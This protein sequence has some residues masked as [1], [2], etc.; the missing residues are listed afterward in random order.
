MYPGQQG[1]P[2]QGPPPP[3]GPYQAPGPYPG[4]QPYPPQQGAPYPPQQGAPYPPY[5]NPGGPGPYPPPQGGGPYPPHGA[6]PHP[7]QHPYPQQQPPQQ[8]API[9][10]VG[11]ARMRLD[12]NLTAQQRTLVIEIQKNVKVYVFGFFFGIMLTSGGIHY[13]VTKNPIGFAA[14]AVGLVG[15]V[16]GVIFHRRTRV[17]KEQLRQ[18]FPDAW[19]SP[20]ADRPSARKAATLAAW[21]NGLLA[22][23]SLVAAGYL[24]VMGAGWGAYG[25]SFG[26][27]ALV[28]GAGIPLSMAAAAA[29]TI[30]Q[31][32]RGIPA[33]AR[34]GRSLYSVIAAVGLLMFKADGMTPKVIGAAVMLVCLGAMK[35]LGDC[36]KRMR[37]QSG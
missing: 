1:Q 8:Q 36:T 31:L 32:L 9:H 29:S 14:A 17:L 18:I 35:L 15:L 6:A 11:E 34:V 37:G 21:L 7:Q 23:L 2:Q 25:N 20:A 19:R 10:Q 26:F 16:V 4:G 22:L 30:P 28:T 27:A 33:G 5:Q 12:P 3:Q 13:G 24:L